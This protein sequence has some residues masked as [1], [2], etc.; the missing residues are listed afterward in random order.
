MSNNSIAGTL[1]KILPLKTISDKLSITEFWIKTDGQYPQYITLQA[2]NDKA[3]QLDGVNI[4]DAITAHINIE[5]RLW[6]NPQGEEKA[7]NSLTLWKLE[8]IGR[9]N[10]VPGVDSGVVTPTNTSEEIQDDLP[11]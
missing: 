1:F 9:T 5:G 2:K 8:V 6:T 11:F 4:G 3:Q 10:A 7:F